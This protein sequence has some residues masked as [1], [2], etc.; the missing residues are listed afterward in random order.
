M[1]SIAG[2]GFAW[3]IAAIVNA[4]RGETFDIEAGSLAF[5]L[6]VYFIFAISAIALLLIRRCKAVGKY[7]EK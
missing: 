7:N 2:I 6:T 5:S 3:T 4:I 1:V